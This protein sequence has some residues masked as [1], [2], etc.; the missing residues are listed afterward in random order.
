MKEIKVSS[1]NENERLNKYLARILP[2]ASMGFIYKMLRKKN[3]TLND[4]KASGSELLK[5]GDQVKIFFSDETFEKFSAR[6]EEHHRD[7]KPIKVLYED[8][9]IIA[10]HKP[11]GLLSQS[12]RK[13]GDCVNERI[14]SYLSS[15]DKLPDDFTPSIVNRLDRNTSGIVLAGKTYQ[16]TRRLTEQIRTRQIIKKYKCICLGSFDKKMT[17]HSFLKEKQQNTVEI[18][19]SPSDGAKEIITEFIPEQKLTGFTFLTVVLHTGRKHQIRAQLAHLGHPIVGD[20]KYGKGHG[21][22]YLHAFS[23]YVPD[24]G[25]I[26]DPVPDEF[27]RFINA[28]I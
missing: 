17:V 5:S 7:V 16:G 12:D 18:L 26:T 3:I 27:G 8:D 19:D 14:L 10:V 1:G 24:V 21:R 22:M 23:V 20:A 6:A 15:R 2:N 13:G 28:H 11:A 9:D 25:V 4:K